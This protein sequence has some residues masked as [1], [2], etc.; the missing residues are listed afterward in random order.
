MYSSDPTAPVKN[1]DGTYNADSN[2]GAASNPHLM[3]GKEQWIKSRVMRSMSNIDLG[4]KFSKQLSFK[5]I[6]GYDYI[7]TKHFEYW[8]PNSV[9]GKAVGGLGSRYTYENRNLTSSSTLRYANTWND[10]HNF[11]ILGGF[12]VTEDELTAIYTT[13]KQY[14]TD[15]LPELGNGQPDGASSEVFGSGIVSLLGYRQL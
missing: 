12:E 9:D 11:D 5:T 1:P 8:S 13:A 14:S 2:W 7:D 15:K 6:F 3:L 4:V 10:V